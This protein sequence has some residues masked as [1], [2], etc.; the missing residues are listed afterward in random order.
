[1]GTL[2]DHVNI[3]RGENGK[4]YFHRV[5]GNGRVISSSQGYRRRWNAK[6]AARRTFP[7]VTIRVLESNSIL[8]G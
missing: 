3:F 6:R 7:G 1:M 5:A 4:W 8:D 2:D